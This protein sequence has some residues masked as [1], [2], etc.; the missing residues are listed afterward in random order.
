MAERFPVSQS[1][2]GLYQLVQD[3]MLKPGYGE[4]LF[5]ESPAASPHSEKFFG[6]LLVYAV[7]R[8]GRRGYYHFQIDGSA[9]NDSWLGYNIAWNP[10][11]ITHVE[12]YME[13]PGAVSE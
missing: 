2:G 13:N 4:Y 7:Q 9:Q 12:T 8:N 3:D 5:R 1:L 10:K 11:K 6:E